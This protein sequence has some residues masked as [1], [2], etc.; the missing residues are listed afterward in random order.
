LIPYA[1]SKVGVTDVETNAVKEPQEV[2]LGVDCE[3]CNGDS[4]LIGGEM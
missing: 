1:E 4:V 3:D 2:I